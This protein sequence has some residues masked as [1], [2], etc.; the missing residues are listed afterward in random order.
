MAPMT[1]TTLEK[2][3]ETAIDKCLPDFGQRLIAR[4][5]MEKPFVAMTREEVCGL[6]ADAVLAYRASI[7]RQADDESDVPF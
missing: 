5:I 3:E 7:D 6:I 4:G 1:P 2:F